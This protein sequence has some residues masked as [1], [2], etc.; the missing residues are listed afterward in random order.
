MTDSVK[1]RRQ[2][3]STR[4]QEQARQTRSAIV[5]A[6]RALFLARGYAGTTVPAVADA[7]G[8]AVETVYK[9]FGNKARLLK[10]VF[11]VSIVGDH[12]PVPML[13]RDLVRA[14]TSEP[15]PRRKFDIYG[16]H[17][18]RAGPRAARVQLLVR[19][20][21]AT[22]PEV[23]EVWDQMTKERLFGMTE[24]A[25]HLSEGGHLRSDITL[26]EARDVLWTYNSVEIY[27]LL[28]L[29]RGWSDERYGRWV[30]DALKCALLPRHS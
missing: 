27:D 28:V 7:A 1:R 30:A 21:S 14:I 16:E 12:K 13:E 23:A 19:A 9:A 10:G 15:E 8:V 29:Q 22:D 20:A 3:R 17:L 6:A 24:F 25:R 4:R 2:Y 26:E 5:E 18:A 11:D